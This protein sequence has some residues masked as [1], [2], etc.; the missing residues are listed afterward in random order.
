MSWQNWENDLKMHKAD[1]LEK[2][3]EQHFERINFWRFVQYTF[4]RQWTKLKR[5][6]NMNGIKIIG[7]IPIYVA[8]DRADVWAN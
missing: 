3:R 8:M 6:A 5:Y 7:D 2:A 4:F 1:A